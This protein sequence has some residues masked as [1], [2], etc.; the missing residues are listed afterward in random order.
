VL[1][2]AS[3]MMVSLFPEYTVVRDFRGLDQWNGIFGWKMPFGTL[4]GFTVILFLFRL[5][6]FKGLN[7]KRR[8]SSLVLYGLGWVL[9]VKSQS[10]TELLGVIAVHFVI[11]LGGLYLIWGHV[12]RRVHWWL[13]AGIMVI[14]ILMAWFE[15]DLLLGLV[16]REVTFTGRLPLW[17]SLEPAIR[18]RIFFGYGFGEAFWKNEVYYL[19]IWKL[20]AWQ[21]VFAHNGYIEAVIDNGIPGLM[22]WILVLVQ[23]GY[24]SLRYFVQNH[25]L[26]ALFFFSWFILIIVMNVGNNH[27]G[28]YET[29][30][31]L[32]LMISLGYVL[33][34]RLDKEK[35][36]FKL[37][38]TP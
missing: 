21:P 23:V 3:L 13:L 33:R 2:T 30:T 20:N 15:R 14:G 16:G 38:P 34:D 12:L 7:W 28:S 22:L 26:P 8:V 19:P 4:M 10:A 9:L 25:N 18:E 36:E 32:L 24:L 17:A 29:F 27:L 6:D 11:L 5:L 1:V 35:I 31:I 37:A